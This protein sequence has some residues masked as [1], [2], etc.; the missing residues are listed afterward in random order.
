MSI[1]MTDA[2]MLITLA[3]AAVEA[4]AQEQEKN[5][6]VSALL[7][8]RALAAVGCLT[9]VSAPQSQAS[10]LRVAAAPPAVSPPRPA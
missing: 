10:A 7:H 4:R 3:Q 8:C 2:D 9:S 1:L 6:R 5:F